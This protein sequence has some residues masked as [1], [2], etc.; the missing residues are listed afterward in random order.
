MVFLWTDLPNN[1]SNTILKSKSL[2]L[3]SL[4][5]IVWHYSYNHIA[6]SAAIAAAGAAAG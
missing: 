6:I 5:E 1:L 4:K 3:S 2:F